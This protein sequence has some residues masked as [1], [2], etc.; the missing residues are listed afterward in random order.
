MSDDSEPTNANRGIDIEASR[1]IGPEQARRLKDE[2]DTHIDGLFHETDVLDAFRFPD[3]DV[4]AGH[5]DSA[6]QYSEIEVEVELDGTTAII[7]GELG[8]QW[9]VKVECGSGLVNIFPG[10]EFTIEG[11][12]VLDKDEGDF[13]VRYLGLWNDRADLYERVRD[14][15][16]QVNNFDPPRHRK[17]A[18]YWRQADYGPVPAEADDAD[19]GDTESGEA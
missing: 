10:Y 18:H 5:F 13:C 4:A 16:E 3:A 17:Q 9:D 12:Q 2:R 19:E 11:G 7:T 8:Y 14:L 6:E 1:G 15:L